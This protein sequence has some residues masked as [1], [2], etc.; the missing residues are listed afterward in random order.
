MSNLNIANQMF[1]NIQDVKEREMKTDVLTKP[2]T[3]VPDKDL[4]NTVFQIVLDIVPFT[5]SQISSTQ[6]LIIMPRLNGDLEKLLF[7]SPHVKLSILHKMCIAHIILTTISQ[8]TKQTPY[9]YTDLKLSNVLYTIQSKT[10]NV[11][12]GDIDDI[13][14]HYNEKSVCTF[15]PPGTTGVI[16]N[17][18]LLDYNTRKIDKNGWYVI[19]WTCMVFV[20]F[21]I[22]HESHILC[23]TITSHFSF[24]H[25]SKFNNIEEFASSKIIKEL[26]F[27]ELPRFLHM[28]QAGPIVTC[29]QQFFTPRGKYDSKLLLENLLHYIGEFT[30]FN[31]FVKP[32]LRKQHIVVRG[33][34]TGSMGHTQKSQHRRTPARVADDDIEQAWSIYQLEQQQNITL[35]DGDEMPTL[36][37]DPQL[38]R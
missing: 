3:N 34:R 2:L 18:H 13:R 21:L 22:M 20:L 5:M 16:N 17:E 6:H 8:L 29:I 32:I 33:L 24:E 37:H 25:I 11:C 1:R 12:L 31:I 14:Q 9:L 4:E 27:V 23:H 28:K 10:V 30:H 36:E 35:Y 38:Y 7:K 15:P 19:G 26:I